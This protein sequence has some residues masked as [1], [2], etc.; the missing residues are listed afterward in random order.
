MKNMII[1]VA[2]VLLMSTF[3]VFQ[4][5][6]NAMQRQGIVLEEIANEV[7]NA[8][9]LDYDDEIYAEG[10]VSYDKTVCVNKGM[11]VF[12]SDL[13]VDL[14]TMTS[15]QKYY[16]GKSIDV[17]IYFFEQDLKYYG[18]KNGTRITADN[19]TYVQG[20]NARNYISNLPKNF[21]EEL[22]FPCVIC[23]IDTGHPRFS[24]DF[25]ETLAIL[26]KAGIYTYKIPY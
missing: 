26:K 19:L 5:D 4:Q 16:D 15:S 17:Y 3:L 25:L 11:E 12:A 14:S 23:V 9:S 13:D 6:I 22:L 1:C 10:L 18:Y 21:E 8:A 24:F 2:I 20:D 7:A